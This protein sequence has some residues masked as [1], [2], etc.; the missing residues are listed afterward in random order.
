MHFQLGACIM[1]RYTRYHSPP[2]FGSWTSTCAT[3]RDPSALEWAGRSVRASRQIRNGTA[4]GVF[5][6][7]CCISARDPESASN[8]KRQASTAV[9]VETLRV[10]FSTIAERRQTRAGWQVEDV[11]LM[12][13]YLEAPAP[14]ARQQRTLESACQQHSTIQYCL[15]LCNSGIGTWS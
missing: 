2:E 15:R 8:V 7:S 11:L 1:S 5:W 9:G 4:L 12:F 14:V 6:D 10:A 3:G 13:V